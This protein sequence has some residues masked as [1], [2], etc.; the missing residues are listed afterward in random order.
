M[1]K[2]YSYKDIIESQLPH[3]VYKSD[4]IESNILGRTFDNLQKSTD[5][6]ELNINPYTSLEEGILSWEKFLKITVK[7]NDTL[8]V[9]RNRV[10]AAFLQYLGDESVITKEEITETKN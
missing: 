4:D 1:S 3:K 9:R 6:L 2:K 7:N 8:E 5:E 10:L